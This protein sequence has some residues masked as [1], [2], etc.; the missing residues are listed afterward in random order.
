MNKKSQEI[1]N[2]LQKKIKKGDIFM[3][4]KLQLKMI[5]NTFLAG[6]VK[7]YVYQI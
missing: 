1:Y 7:Y 2:K 5:F 4:N 3:K 6:G